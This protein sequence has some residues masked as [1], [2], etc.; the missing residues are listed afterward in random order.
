MQCAQ[1]LTCVSITSC[2]SQEMF[3]CVCA[4]PPVM[5]S[6]FAH[7]HTCCT[8]PCN[9]MCWQH[10]DIGRWQ[11]A[12]E[13][14]A[15]RCL[16][17]H[18]GSALVSEVCPTPYKDVSESARRKQCNITAQRSCL[19]RARC[20]LLSNFPHRELLCLLGAR[21]AEEVKHIR[22]WLHLFYGCHDYYIAEVRLGWL[23]IST[24]LSWWG[25]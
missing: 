23:L 1:T 21:W 20:R 11:K 15:E 3:E 5:S 2:L 6:L 10:N 24:P 4:H 19:Y 17:R 14:E 13:H 8:T 25:L 22:T 16:A 18:T 9:W 7:C 12:A